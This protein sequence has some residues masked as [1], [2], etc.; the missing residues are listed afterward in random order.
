MRSAFAYLINT[1]CHAAQ[2]LAFVSFAL[3]F[4]MRCAHI[5]AFWFNCSMRCFAVEVVE[6]ADCRA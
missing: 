4:V 5:S 2:L 3:L 6:A 1:R